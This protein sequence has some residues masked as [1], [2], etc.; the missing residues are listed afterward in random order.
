[1]PD[2]TLRNLSV[3]QIAVLGDAAMRG[4]HVALARGLYRQLV[5][6][7]PN[8]PQAHTRLGL[9]KTMGARTLMMLEVLNTMERHPGSHTFV[10][11]GIATWLKTPPFTQD[12]RFMEIEEANSDIAANGN[13]NWHWNLLTVATAAQYVKD[14]P[15]DFVEVGVYK[16]HTTKFVAEYVE[17]STWDKRWWLYD[18]FEGIPE[19]QLD[20]GREH[21]TAAAY[22][23][24]Y[25]FEEVRDR[26]APFGN[27]DVIKG[28]VPEI[29]AER[30]PERIAFLHVDLNTSA[31][32]IAALDALYDRVSPGG[33]IVLDDFGWTAARA[34]Y[35][36]EVA[37]FRARG[38]TVFALPTGQGL[39]IKPH[40]R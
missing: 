13:Q 5:K 40:P 23:A 9:T 30:S 7:M 2:I 32:E 8:S 26:F 25:S 29:L 6:L 39:F 21:L 36:A 37:W 22:G 35:D 31:A 12:L 38:L 1:V 18:T 3:E 16:G 4:R 27:I 20:A 28:R 19:D 24:P 17:F 10:G 11:D 33:I 14:V 34:Q 15:G